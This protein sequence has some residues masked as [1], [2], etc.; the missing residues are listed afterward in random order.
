MAGV[1]EYGDA[2]L[3]E[4]AKVVEQQVG[5]INRIESMISTIDQ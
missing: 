2:A 5:R 4:N 1:F 3:I